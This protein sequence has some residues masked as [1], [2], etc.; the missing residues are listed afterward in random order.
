MKHIYAKRI[1]AYKK[2]KNII[3]ITES[4]DNNHDYKYVTLV[5]LFS[6]LLNCNKKKTFVIFHILV[7]PD[8]NESSTLFKNFS[9]NV[10]IIIYNMGNH[11]LNRKTE[12]YP[13]AAFYRILTPAFVD[14]DRII[15]LDGETIT[16][17]DLSEMFNLDFDDN[18]ILGFY[19]VNAAGID[20][21]G[22]KSNVYINSG[23]ILLNCKKVREDNKTVELFNVANSNIKLIN[24]DQSLL[25]YLLYPKIGR[26]PSKFG[27]QNFANRDDIELYL[28]KLRTKVPIEE[29]E[30][31]IKNPGIVHSCLCYPKLW[32]NKTIYTKGLSNCDK[33]HDCSCKKYFDLWHSFAKQTDYYEEIIKFTGTMN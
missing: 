12:R 9:H 13:Q 3:H 5:S 22:I 2:R 10:E 27:T 14:S 19:D 21:L 29:L 16:F 25:N 11:F 30:E 20:Y 6:I 17:S 26:L 15:H 31:G 7:T 4:L 1:K 18:Y 32:S 28:S 8:F 33:R 23:V 24:V